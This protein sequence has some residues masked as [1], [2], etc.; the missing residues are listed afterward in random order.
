M[1]EPVDYILFCALSVLVFAAGQAL[2]WRAGVQR[3]LRI[4][5]AAALLALLLAGWVMTDAWG[6]RA[7]DSV[8]AMLT[9]YAPTYAAEMTELGHER[10]TPSTPAND[11]A[12]LEM[13]EAEKRWLTANPSVNDIYTFHRDADGTVRLFVD[14][15]TDYDHDGRYDSSREQRTPLGEIY[16]EG[17]DPALRAA[18]AG[19]V[20]F[21]DQPVTDRWGTWVSAYAP[22]RDGD[23]RVVA[24]LGVDF[25]ARRWTAAIT[26]ARRMAMGYLF[27]FVLLVSGGA[28]LVAIVRR[29]HLAALEGSRAK[30]EF[31]A[32]MSHEIRTPINGVVGMA[33]LL[34]DT[35]LSREQREFAA[36]I[37]RS[38]DSLSGIVDN[39]L[40]FS[41]IESGR[42]PL[43][44][45]AFAPARVG[46]EV[47]AALDAAARERGLELRID[48]SPTLPERV[49]GDPARLQQAIANLVGN[50][51]K[52]TERGHV[53]IAVGCDAVA[54]GVAALRFAVE[55]TGIGIPREI[56]SRIFEHF[57]QGDGS[58]TRRHGGTGLGLATTRRLVELMG[59]TIE[60]KSEV[61]KGSTFTILIRLPLAQAVEV[62]AEEDVP[63][64]AGLAA[65][66]VPAGLRV[67][68][69]D[70]NE[71]NRRVAV[72]MLQRLECEVET[73]ANGR[74]ALDRMGSAA[75]DVVLMDCQMPVMDGYEAAR[76]WRRRER[77]PRRLS[78]VALTANAM[79]GDRE[80]CLEAGMDD[81][82]PKPVQPAELA[83]T[84]AR[85]APATR[86][87]A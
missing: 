13:I 58:S 78:I 87:A 52:F 54:A 23:G 53:T 41:R 86:G 30:T 38:A 40:D 72:H 51:V 2:S 3:G 42:L 65:T 83:R 22:I 63:G 1:S 4:A 57:R 29:N 61:G 17:D 36:T 77:G 7:R 24:V 69:V 35:P 62:A 14:S 81:Y 68:V 37:K 45:A 64:S 49:L 48:I 71:V 60:L 74:E 10:L 9:G 19:T 5:G 43:E 76:A 67:L 47:F 21:D 80:R 25:D 8:V 15:E 6:R 28:A 70:D 16:D 82:L 33:A 59:G 75:F 34:L 46:R 55:D 66:M 32:T 73:A 85:W 50:A 11:P 31:L 20:G 79:Q 56:R 39:I 12:Y 18:F 26:R 27:V 44:R 84:L